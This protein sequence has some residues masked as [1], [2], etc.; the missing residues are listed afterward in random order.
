MSNDDVARFV[1]N[2]RDF[3]NVAKDLCNEALY[4]GT[5]DNVTAIV[6][7]LRNRRKPAPTN[8][9]NGQAAAVS[10][11]SSSSPANS[12]SKKSN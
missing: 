8:E 11:A 3:T 7:D 1:F 9:I 10:T 2:L 5:T 6:V 4:L 12:N